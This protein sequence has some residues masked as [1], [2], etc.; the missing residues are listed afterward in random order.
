MHSTRTAIHSRSIFPRDPTGNDD[1]STLRQSALN[2]L[3][4][5][6]AEVAKGRNGVRCIFAGR[7]VG[8]FKP[9]VMMGMMIQLECS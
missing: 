4:F 6:E 5:E 3:I 8:P 2:Q 9:A 1:M 7:R